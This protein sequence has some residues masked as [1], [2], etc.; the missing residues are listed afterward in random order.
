MI[1]IITMTKLNIHEIKAHFSRCLDRVA[2][3]ETIIV[4][5]RNVPVAE[6]RPV[7]AMPSRKRPVGLAGKDYPGFTVSDA[8][9]EPLPEDIIA[10]F[11]G[12]DE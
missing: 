11:S 10:G 5:K 2:R 9:F 8:F 4:C 1:Y 3:G 7:K 6:I 12:E